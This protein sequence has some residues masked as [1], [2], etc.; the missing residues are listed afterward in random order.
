MSI[1]TA[2]ARIQAIALSSTDISITNAPS[3]PVE[4]LAG[5]MPL[6]LTHLVSGQAQADDATAA[7]LIHTVNC[8]VFFNRTSLTQSYKQINLFVPEFLKR[9]SGDPT[10]ASTVDTIVFP[11]TY[12]VGPVQFNSILTEMASFA[13]TVKFREASI[14]T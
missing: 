1:D 9:L 12:V 8:D 11:V 4:D 10:L 7:R 2:I 13:I 14:T 3:Y 5:A 6:V